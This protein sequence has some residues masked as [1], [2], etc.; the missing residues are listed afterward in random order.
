MFD[1]TI[2]VYK[3]IDFNYYEAIFIMTLYYIT[4]KHTAAF[5][6]WFLCV[7]IAAAGLD[8]SGRA[9]Q[10]VSGPNVEGFFSGGNHVGMWLWFHSYHSQRAVKC[11]VAFT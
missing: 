6:A 5:K 8:P 10:R 3:L 4:S 11:L 9:W 2:F 1:Q 7:I